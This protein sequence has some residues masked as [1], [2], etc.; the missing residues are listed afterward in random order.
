VLRVR[1]LDSWQEYL[2]HSAGWLISPV[3]PELCG[4]GAAARVGEAE[5]G[6]AGGAFGQG[7]CENSGAQVVVVVDLGG[8]LARVGPQDAPRV[9]D[10]ASF[11]CD[12]RGEE[13]G[14]QGRAVEALADVGPGGYG[15]QWR[16]SAAERALAPMPPRRITG[17]YPLSWSASAS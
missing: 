16:A 4:L 6:V 11:E 9:L 1:R 3:C 12:R 10:E 2:S 14:V 17:S 7:R 5:A 8:G 15:Q 13:Q